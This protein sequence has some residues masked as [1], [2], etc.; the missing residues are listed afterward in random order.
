MWCPEIAWVKIRIVSEAEVPKVIPKEDHQIIECLKDD[1]YK[2]Q[3][4]DS[5]NQNN[6]S[7]DGFWDIARNSMAERLRLSQEFSVLR[8]PLEDELLWLF[9]KIVNPIID[10]SDWAP[11]STVTKSNVSSESLESEV[12]QDL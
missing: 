11:D 2:Y 6:S 7:T 10:P 4:S 8:N 9:H 12:L 5:A 3:S 1:L